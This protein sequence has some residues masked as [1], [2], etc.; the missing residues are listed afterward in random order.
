MC[1]QR[2]QDL[3]GHTTSDP[4]RATLAPSSALK[5]CHLRIR[6]ITWTYRHSR[7]TSSLAARKVSSATTQLRLGLK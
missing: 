7:Y 6:H 1:L 2:C 5:I 4:T 3:L